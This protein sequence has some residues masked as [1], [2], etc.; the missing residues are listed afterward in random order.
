METVPP[1]LTC[2][3]EARRRPLNSAL[4][5]YGSV[6]RVPCTRMRRVGAA[7]V[8]RSRFRPHCPS[9]GCSAVPVHTASMLKNGA[10]PG[11]SCSSARGAAPTA[12]SSRASGLPEP[13]ARCALKETPL[14][15]WRSLPSSHAKPPLGRSVGLCEQSR[16][17]HQRSASA[18]LI[19]VAF[20][21]HVVL[22]VP[23]QAQASAHTAARSG[24]PNAGAQVVC[25]R[26]RKRW[27]GAGHIAAPGSAARYLRGT[28]RC[29][30]HAACSASQ[31]RGVEN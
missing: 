3:R 14:P 29:L 22:P 1:P 5:S 25:T 9:C 21:G 20:S 4:L 8:Q 26:T 12:H 15:Y 6:R 10:Q 17:P 28:L 2:A 23:P 30:C 19:R 7:M 13:T 11:T 24:Q 16:V 31:P 18:L 27:G